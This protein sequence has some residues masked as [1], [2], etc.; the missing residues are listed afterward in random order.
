MAVTHALNDDLRRRIA[1]LREEAIGPAHDPW[2]PYLTVGLAEKALLTS[3]EVTV[4]NTC[5]LRCEHC[6]V[7][8]LLTDEEERLISLDELMAR[9]DEVDT[10]LTFSVTGGEPAASQRLV[11]EVTRP[12]SQY[13]KSRGLRTQVNTNLTLPLE[14][15]ESFV[16]WVDVLHIS[17]NY[18]EPSE[19][20]RVAY[21]Y[22]DR[23]PRDPEM[24][25]RRMD[26]N[27]R[28][29]ASAGVFVSAETILTH[30]TLPRIDEIHARIAELG[31]VATRSTR[32]TP[33]T[34]RL[35]CAC[36]PSRS[37]RTASGG[38]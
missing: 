21:A 18:P 25:L 37:W 2:D 15:Y 27:I 11:D 7:G 31:C 17:Y 19:F 30:A 16:E 32:S 5:N 3:I 14:R 9:I 24:L 38:S 29:L 34:S 6:A 10:L 13:A 36:R 33:A 4:T 23:T 35:A 20:A 12:L 1:A 28:A 22:A 26:A 8:D